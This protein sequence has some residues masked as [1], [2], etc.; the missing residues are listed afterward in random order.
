VK[1]AN[2]EGSIRTLPNGRWEASKM[3][4][5]SRVSRSG[6]TRQEALNRL[7]EATRKGAVPRS[8]TKTV[9]DAVAAHL[10]HLDARVAAGTLKP[11]SRSYYEDM[12]KHAPVELRLDKVQARDI[13]AWQAGLARMSRSTRRGAFIAL[14]AA[15]ATA[16]RDRLTGNDP[17][18]GLQAPSGARSVE[19]VHATA[20][21]IA[22]LLEAADEPWRTLWL[23][24]AYTGLRRGEALALEWDDIDLDRAVL[25]VRDGK[26]AR[27]RRQVPLV[28]AVVAALQDVPRTG[29]CPFPFDGRAALHRFYQHRPREG[30]TIHSLRHGVA[31][32][33]LESGASVH[34]VS[35]VL[36]HSSVSVTMDNYSHSVA[37]AER[38]A[39]GLL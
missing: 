21:D 13:E 1:R 30:L 9:A 19:P 4:G 2:G 38:D 28:P 3:I 7:A 23:V 24:L 17:F 25:Y 32:R 12:L 5:G 39:L 29:P 20:E 37:Q 26:T 10:V 14:K 33:L 34:V 36:G 27:A 31:T 18:D 35:A 11:T 15:F 22:A 6:K 8:K 16:R